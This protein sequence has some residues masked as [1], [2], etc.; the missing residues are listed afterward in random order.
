M[1]ISPSHVLALIALSAQAQIPAPAPLFS[2]SSIRVVGRNSKLLAAGMVLEI[3]G[4][5]LVRAV[6]S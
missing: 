1:Q 3:Y 4:R 2:S 6:A 5:D